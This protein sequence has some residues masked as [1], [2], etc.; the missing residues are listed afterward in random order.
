MMV[1]DDCKLVYGDFVGCLC[2]V[3]IMPRTERGDN[4]RCWY[5][6]IYDDGV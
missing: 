4:V 6:M 1:Y 2:M 3:M 5:K